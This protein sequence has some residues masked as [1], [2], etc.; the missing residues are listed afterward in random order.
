MP[1]LQTL[2]WLLT[3]EL[4]REGRN[5]IP[6]ATLARRALHPARGRSGILCDPRAKE[7]PRVICRKLR[8]GIGTDLNQDIRRLQRLCEVYRNEDRVRQSRVVHRRYRRGQ[9]DQ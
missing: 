9:D 2:S 8:I 1:G 7:W 6:V 4:M 3:E 5:G